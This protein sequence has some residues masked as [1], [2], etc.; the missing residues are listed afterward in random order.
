MT[1]QETL[2]RALAPRVGDVFEWRDSRVTVKCVLWDGTVGALLECENWYSDFTMTA[3]GWRDSVARTLAHDGVTFTP[4][5]D[6][7]VAGVVQ[8]AT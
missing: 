6:T 7:A 1:T 3:A 2:A 5:L 4:A 8:C